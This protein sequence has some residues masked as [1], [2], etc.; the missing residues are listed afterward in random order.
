MYLPSRL[1]LLTMQGCPGNWT[2]YFDD[3]LGLYAITSCKLFIHIVFTAI[4][5]EKWPKI[6]C[7]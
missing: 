7:W 3:I 1:I 5:F 6:F 2:I 4:A